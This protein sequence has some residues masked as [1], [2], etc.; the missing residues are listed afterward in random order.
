ML[1]A[2]VGVTV[3]SVMYYSI[4]NMILQYNEYDF[5]V[6][7]HDVIRNILQCNECDVVTVT[8]YDV[9]CNVLL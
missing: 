2:V 1:C 3:H 8:V 6:T 9:M 7:V 5:T 4:M